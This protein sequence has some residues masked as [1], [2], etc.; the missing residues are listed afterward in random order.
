[1]KC[2]RCD[3]QAVFYVTSASYENGK[4][5]NLGGCLCPA[6][7]LE[8]LASLAN[9]HHFTHRLDASYQPDGFNYDDGL[10]MGVLACAKY[11]NK[12][13]AEFMARGKQLLEWYGEEAL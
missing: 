2:A 8:H 7:L 6:C 10:I 1:M 12:S 3:E 11:R 4:R 9:A 5:K 13:V